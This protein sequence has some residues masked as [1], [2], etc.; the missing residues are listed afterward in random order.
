[1][2]VTDALAGVFGSAGSEAATDAAEE[3]AADAN[4][5]EQPAAAAAPLVAEADGEGQGAGASEQREVAEV[6]ES[7]FDRV[8][9]QAAV[10]SSMQA[11]LNRPLPSSPDKAQHQHQRQ[12]QQKKRPPLAPTALPAQGRPEAQAAPPPQLQQQE[13]VGAQSVPAAAQAVEP[14]VPPMAG[15]AE[16]EEAL[17]VAMASMAEGAALAVPPEDGEAPPEPT[18]LPQEAA[19]EPRP[20]AEPAAAL[21]QPASPAADAPAALGAAA[22]LAA[23][24]GEEEA[25]PRDDSLHLVAPRKSP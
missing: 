6:L 23:G 4:E 3:Q 20:S 11:A 13:Q 17:P 24:A 18:A 22:T 14:K 9:Q 1:M 25:A 7:I 8:E 21:P 15:T 10:E 19:E 2:L 16:A 5:A 12:R